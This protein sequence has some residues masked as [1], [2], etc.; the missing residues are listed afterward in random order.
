MVILGKKQGVLPDSEE[1]WLFRDIAYLISHHNYAVPEDEWWNL[2]DG[3]GIQQEE[4]PSMSFIS[5]A[6]PAHNPLNNRPPGLAG[7]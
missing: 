2:L 6:N 1:L 3:Y 5:F 4:E 7:L